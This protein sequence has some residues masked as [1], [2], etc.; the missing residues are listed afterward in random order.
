L[1]EVIKKITVPDSLLVELDWETGGY[2]IRY[3]IVSESKNINSHWSPTYVIPVADFAD[4]EG[5]FYESVS[6]T[7]MEKYIITVVWDDV[8]NRPAY[9]IFVSYRGNDPDDAFAYD[10]DMFHCH[11]T[12]K[13]HNYSFVQRDNVV[14]NR[15]IVQPASNKKLIK[16]SFIIYDSDNPIDTGS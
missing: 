4:V 10:S 8:F 13:T 11:G 6:D 9:D 5:Q 1:A 14:S 12:S 3:R 2:L 16:P 15:I 7:D